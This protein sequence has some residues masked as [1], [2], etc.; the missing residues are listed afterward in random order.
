MAGGN[1]SSIAR[2]RVMS[3]RTTRADLEEMVQTYRIKALQEHDEMRRW[4]N[5]ALAAEPSRDWPK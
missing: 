4:Q 5:R 1:A 3:I 2:G